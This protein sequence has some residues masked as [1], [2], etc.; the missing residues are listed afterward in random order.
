[1]KKWLVLFVG[2]LYLSIASIGFGAPKKDD[3]SILLYPKVGAVIFMDEG[4][5]GDDKVLDQVEK[6]IQQKMLK[7]KNTILALAIQE[8]QKVVNNNYIRED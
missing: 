6:A 3:V 7:E 1:M 8:L 5:R 2:I 4:L